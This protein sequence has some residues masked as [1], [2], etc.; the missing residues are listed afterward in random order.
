MA[1]ID[2]DSRIIVCQ[3]GDRLA[4]LLIDQITQ[5][6]S[7]QENQIE[8]PPATFSGRD[9]ALLDGVGRV[10]EN[11]LILLNLSSVLTVDNSGF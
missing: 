4:G 11:V 5:V 7:I 9:R 10:Q 6:T 3:D 8:P 1:E 2:Q